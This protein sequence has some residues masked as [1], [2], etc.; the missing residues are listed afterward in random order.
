MCTVNLSEFEDFGTRFFED[1]I[2][3]SLNKKQRST[4]HSTQAAAALSLRPRTV[5]TMWLD[6][7]SQILVT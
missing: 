2:E 4:V 7:A 6:A 5:S 1:E 3:L